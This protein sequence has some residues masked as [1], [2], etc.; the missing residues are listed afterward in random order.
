MAKAG[1][2]SLKDENF[3]L[4]ASSTEYFSNFGLIQPMKSQIFGPFFVQNHL[5]F[6]V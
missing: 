5:L 3:S 6:H 4:V 1:D 2:E